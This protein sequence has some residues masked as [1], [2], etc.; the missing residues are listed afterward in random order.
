MPKLLIQGHGSYRI[1]ADDGRV[2]FAEWA[3]H[4]TRYQR[5]HI[6]RPNVR[7]EPPRAVFYDD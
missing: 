7:P 3:H 2:V 6:G 1:T 5:L 4:T